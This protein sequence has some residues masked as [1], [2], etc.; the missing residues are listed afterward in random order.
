[1]SPSEGVWPTSSLSPR[2]RLLGWC[3]SLVGVESI[4]ANEGELADRLEPWARAITGDRIHRVRHTLL[5]G[6]PADDKPTI[7]LA[8]H[9]D[10]VRPP[11]GTFEGPRVDGDKLFGLGTSD[12][13]AGVAVMC[14]LAE[15]HREL[16]DSG[17]LVVILY[18]REEGPH[19]DNGLGILLDVYP[20]LHD[21][22]LAIC[23]EPT[24]NGVQLGCVGGLHAT[25]TYRGQ[26]AHSARPWQGDNAIHKAGPLLTRLAGLERVPVEC[27]PLTFF[28]VISA[29]TGKGGRGTTIVPDQFDLNL[30]YRFAPGKSLSTAED[31]LRAFVGAEA[32]VVITDRAPSGRVCDDNLLA[33][34]LVELSRQVPQA[35]QAWTDV[36]RLTESGIDAVNYGPGSPSQ[37]HQVGEFVVI[38]QMVHSFERLGELLATL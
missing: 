14:A 1:M 27:G 10:T 5:L 13:K 26:A 12:M 7:A 29:T 20:E 9:L 33:E 35:K 17:K 30:N 11:N 25:V 32:E 2:E 34:T 38:D 18:D 24:D 23:M 28:E 8:G 21:I 16:I 19:D 31:E 36:A 4:Y 37:A 22:D 15:D 6:H 3:R